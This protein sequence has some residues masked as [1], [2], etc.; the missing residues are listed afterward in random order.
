M[1]EKMHINLSSKI[2]L[3][4]GIL[5]IFVPFF[6]LIIG[7]IGIGFSKKAKKEMF[8]SDEGGKGLATSGFICSIFGIVIQLITLLAYILY[9][10]VTR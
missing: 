7:I 5:S 1:I 9:T 6:G 2:S 8:V 4:L 10:S 3:T